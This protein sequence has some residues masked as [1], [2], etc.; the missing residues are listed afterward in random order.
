MY[1]SPSCFTLASHTKTHTWNANESRVIC[2]SPWI[3]SRAGVVLLP[4]MQPMASYLCKWNLRPAFIGSQP[5][6]NWEQ[7]VLLCDRCVLTKSFRSAGLVLK[8]LSCGAIWCFGDLHWCERRQ[9]GGERTFLRPLRVC[10][11]YFGL[12]DPFTLLARQC[13]SRPLPHS[14]LSLGGTSSL[15]L[16]KPGPERAVVA[17]TAR[18]K[19]Q[20]R[21]RQMEPL[22]SG[23]K[24]TEVN[25]RLRRGCP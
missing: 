23:D 11:K 8:Q 5:V 13:G 19:R 18:Q 6:S 1:F 20:Q 24:Q 3:R 4:L 22:G 2:A 15:S 14:F 10:L 16:A 21:D 12:G 7:V 17:F 9:M 25:R